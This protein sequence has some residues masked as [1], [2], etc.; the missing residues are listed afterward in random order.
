MT[1]L[2]IQ[3]EEL[4]E[5]LVYEDIF[6]EY[7]NAFL[8]LP[9]FPVTLFYDRLTGNVQELDGFLPETLPGYGA[10]DLQRDRTMSWLTQERLS[11]FRR[12]PLYLEYKLA[13]LLL[14]ALEDP[15]PLS[16]YGIRG[17]SRQ[18]NSAALSTI[19]SHPST[20]DPHLNASS[21][22]PERLVGQIH[23]LPSRTRSTPAATGY[24]SESYKLSLL[25]RYGDVILKLYSRDP[26]SLL[27]S[28]FA[29]SG[30]MLVSDSGIEAPQETGR[31]AEES[32]AAQSETVPSTV[33]AEPNLARSGTEAEL[34]YHQDTDMEWATKDE[35][36]AAIEEE[37]SFLQQHNLTRSSL[38]RLKEEALGTREGMGKFVDFLQDTLGSYL[39][40][41]WMDC[42]EF[43]ECSIDLE[44]NYSPVEARHRSVHLFRCIQGKYQVCLSPECQEQIRVSQQ[45]WGPTFHALKRPQYDALRR[46]RS[47]WVP[48]FLIHQQRYRLGIS[49]GL[50]SSSLVASDLVP[51]ING[52]TCTPTPGRQGVSPKKSI[53]DPKN[54]VT[55]KSGLQ[56]THCDLFRNPLLHRMLPALRSD[57][58]AGG[59]FLYYLQRFEQPQ[60]TQA[61]FLWQELDE[62]CDWESEQTDGLSQH[63]V[64]SHSVG[65]GSGSAG[66]VQQARGL[67]DS[68]SDGMQR[69]DLGSAA[70]VALTALCEPWMRFLRYDITSFLEYCVPASFHETQESTE[71]SP[72]NPGQ[73]RTKKQIPGGCSFQEGK[74]TLHRKKRI[75]G[76]GQV[77]RSDGDPRHDPGALLA[78]LQH[79]AIY[80]VYRKTVQDTEEPEL[81]KA[82]EIL[83]ALRGA[84]GEKKKMIL[85]LVQKVV[86]LDSIQ[87]PL[88]KGLRKR[89]AAE[90]SKGRISSSC[91]EETTDFLS[92]LL[93]ESF[94]QFW[95]EVADRL[96]DYG[97]EQPGNE[98]WGRL[99]PILQVVTAKMVLKRLHGR[100]SNMCHLAQAQPNIED[101]AAFH[102]AMQVAAEGW[103]TLEV[104]HFLRFLQVHGPPEGLPLL[105][106]NLLCCLEVQKYK[107][108]HHP[109]PDQG[110]LKRKVKVIQGR[111]LSQQT[112]P[113]L[114]LSPEALHSFLQDTEAAMHSE[115]PSLSIFAHLQD[116]LCDSLLPFW[117][118]FRKAW[119]DRSPASA[120]R[121]PVLRVQQMLRKRLA[122]FEVEQTPLKTF[123]LPL[124]QL[125]PGRRLQPMITFSFSMSRGVTLKENSAQDRGSQMPTPPGSRRM[126]QAC[127]L[128]PISGLCTEKMQPLTTL[129]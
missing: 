121:V 95:N 2:E 38:Q 74:M 36:S 60:K 62:Y 23:R 68:G 44:A 31:K 94:G 75:T 104:L 115:L 80:K 64:S 110:L 79:R 124:V 41:F 17:Y 65:I 112:N 10:S 91:M 118:G 7:F 58:E 16:R 15:H 123:H 66:H 5:L 76:A 108:A 48:R 55:P 116:S 25:E 90:L 67:L 6:L 109:M 61:F 73:T 107:N 30:D 19:P 126:S 50:V 122:L 37:E 26:D 88:L 51:P 117:A 59:T 78:M 34:L 82:L 22:H 24:L 32:P 11:L 129:S 43:K 21:I 35:V 8:A 77:S 4:E 40:H 39:L 28:S 14:R 56:E 128:P 47:Y 127:E 63:P 13:K 42:E 87:S 96:K 69:T 86:E 89:L 70:R 53:K 81:L 92:S 45:N 105:E 100:K 98:G 9:A 12:S 102:R 85:G 111:F 54:P 101:I 49:R 72:Q 97:V 103:P 84:A 106:N 120:Q 3:E 33:L 119:L 52:S 1:A 71:R 113:V 57:R 99:E 114:Q 125:S 83:H 93:A 18:S 46:L 27:C 20:A 29:D